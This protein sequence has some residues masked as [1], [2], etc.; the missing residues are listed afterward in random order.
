MTA[1]PLLSSAILCPALGALFII[2]TAKDDKL[3]K[4]IALISS[5][6]SLLVSILIYLGFDKSAAGFQLQEIHHL[7]RSLN[8][9]YHLGIDGISIFFIILT[10][11]RLN[12]NLFFI[13]CQ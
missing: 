3:I 12:S 4:I 9:H 8:M 11:F 2:L 7:I 1:F 10:I 13:L 6:A 5:L